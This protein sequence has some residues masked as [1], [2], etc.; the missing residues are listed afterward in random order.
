MDPTPSV[1]TLGHALVDVVA[2]CDDGLLDALGLTKGT[3]Q[4]SDGEEA[5]RL[6]AA[7]AP[8]TEMSGGSAA[9]TAACLASLGGSVQFMG[10]VADDPL[11][12]TFA[13]D[14]RTVGVRFESQPATPDPGTPGTGR[15]LVFVTPD[16][17][18]TMC[19]SL[20]IGEALTTAELD[21]EAIRAARVLY[22]EGYMCKDETDAA[23]RAAIGTARAAGT[24]VA[25]SASDPAWVELRRDDMW[26]LLPEM[27]L[28]LA[29]EPEALGLAG[30]KDLQE[31]IRRL[32]E[33]CPIVAVTLGSEGSLVTRRGGETVAVP[34]EPVAHAIDTT[35]AGDS[36]AAGFLYGMVHGMDL[37]SSAR[38]GSLAA[39]EIVSHL[40]ARPLVSLAELAVA[41]GLLPSS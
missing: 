10:K 31:A 39:A 8:E 22:F 6:Y 7:M 16:A 26:E 34:A 4:L 38:L 25:M 17:E 40:G 12:V 32:V 18:K 33:V 41:A 1:V 36:F 2:T 13:R 27:D 21:L 30:T 15:C 23:L 28:L 14:I 19:T 37:E 5:E 20:G 35:G 9:N 3:M 11:G 24:L 29:N